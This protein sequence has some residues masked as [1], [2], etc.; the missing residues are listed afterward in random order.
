VKK[1]IAFVLESLH[2]GGAEKS[3][4]TLL[5][6]LDYSQYEIVLL[7]IVEGGFFKEQVPKEAQWQII[8][9]RN[10]TWFQR[11]R[12]F[13]EKKINKK[14]HA[15]QILW[16]IISDNYKEI[17]DFYDVAIAYGQG[18]PTYFVAEKMKAKKKF[19]WINVDYKK[20]GYNSNFD[21]PF[22]KKYDALIAV[23][24][25]VKT[26]IEHVFNYSALQ[27]RVIKDITDE[28]AVKQQAEKPTRIQ[29]LKENINILTVCRLAPEKGL[30]MAMETCKL[31]KEKG[32][33]VKWYFIGEGSERSQLELLIKKYNL[34]GT[35]V[36]LGAKINPYPY[37]KACDIYVQTSL[38]E[39]LGLTV[40]EAAILQKPIVCTNFPTAYNILKDNETGLI[41]EMNPNA[42]AEQIE[43]LIKDESL[44]KK[45][46]SNLEQQENKDKE[47]SLLQFEN[48]INMP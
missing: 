48:L 9:A 11:F 14:K 17:S 10:P 5:Q 7:T 38:F 33:F 41:A 30:S 27:I 22:Y 39:G 46:I 3:L 42:I 40:I 16:P 34:Q 12:Y 1:K 19:A 23:S 6:N 13:L 31:L 35:A 8:S 47:Q 21:L 44:R 32:Y 29:F 24:E 43:K 45:L 4:V 26:T 37:M 15:S 28:I 18:F 25:E 2:L 36:L 20:A